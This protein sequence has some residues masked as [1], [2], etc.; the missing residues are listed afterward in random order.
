MSLFEKTDTG[1]VIHVDYNRIVFTR[2]DG[3]VM[4]RYFW[5]D[6]C[7]PMDHIVKVGDIVE[8][9]TFRSLGKDRF[10]SIKFISR[11]ES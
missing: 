11:K 4:Q 5:S 3:V 1:K 6:E 10:V 7:P 2:M 8:L 9:K